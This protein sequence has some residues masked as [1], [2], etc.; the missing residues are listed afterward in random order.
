MLVRSRRLHSS[1]HGSLLYA[2]EGIVLD[3]AAGTKRGPDELS[4]ACI[5]TGSNSASAA[6]GNDRK[7][8]KGNS[9]KLK[10]KGD[11]KKMKGD[12]K[13]MKVDNKKLKLKG[14]REQLK[15]K[16]DSRKL[17]GDKFKIDSET[18]NLKLNCKKLKLKGD[19]SKL[20]IDEKLKFKLDCKEL[21]LRGDG[22]KLK[23]DGK[24][25]QGNSTKVKSFN[26]SSGVPSRV[27]CI[28]ELPGDVTEDEVIFLGLPFG[29]VTN[30]Q[31][32]KWENQAFIE[33]NTKE[34]AIT[35]VKHYTS[36]TP[37]L[38]GQPICIQ[39]SQHKELNT[40]RLHNQAQVQS[41][42]QALNSFQSRNLALAASAPA[43]GAGTIN[44]GPVGTMNSAA[45]DAVDVGAVNDVEVGAGPLCSVSSSS[46]SLGMGAV[47]S[48]TLDVGPVG[49]ATV[50]AGMEVTAQ[51]PVLR[52]LIEN[53]LNP[54]SLDMLHLIFSHFGKVL[55][56]I[57][58]TQNNTFQVLLQYAELLSAHLAKLFLDRWN[59]FGCT[60]HIS[61]STSS[62]LNVNYNN[63]NIRI[64]T[65]P[66]LPFCESQF[67]QD[68]SLALAFS[69][70]PIM[71]AP[72]Q[73]GAGFPSLFIP[74]AA[75]HCYPNELQALLSL[76]IASVSRAAI[77]GQI[78]L[79]GLAPVAIQSVLG[80]AA[81]G[82][83]AIPGPAP[84]AIPLMSGAA[85]AEAGQVAIPAPAQDENCVLLVSN[86]NPQKIRIRSLFIIFGVYGDV[87]RVK[88]FFK[89]KS[90]ALVQMANG[91]Q[92]KMAMSHLNGHVLYG[93]RMLITVT[94]HKV[95][96]LLRKG[97][98]D[99]GLTKDYSNSRLHR[100]R[101]VC[102]KYFQNVS[103]PSAHLYFNHIPR[104]TSSYHLK[105]LLSRKGRIVKKFRFFRKCR[106][107]A[108]AEMG[109]VGEAIHALIDLHNYDLGRGHHLWVNFSNR[110]QHHRKPPL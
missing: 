108:L 47:C 69:A 28:R 37:M 109:S 11:S 53:P 65:S 71:S 12:S 34:A 44:T 10:V 70:A 43:V 72:L 3:K 29:K 19:S 4:S 6:N 8:F 24:K 21:K 106:T 9:K 18:L 36:M 31:M 5:T 79:A 62:I 96:H 64:Y 1:P 50:D 103:P 27:I 110:P 81:A 93:K 82:Q 33:M 104:F 61:F 57:T 23:G 48:G 32:M 55:K 59:I 73:L 67:S 25:M 39:F 20:K 26:S 94:P 40:S 74:Q 107:M 45:V 102:S 17:N 42:L 14:D 13:K 51:K 99:L 90:Q 38:R 88:I 105:A 7:K 77:A 87:Q 60:V 95:V 92:A 22:S 97:Q 54:F 101:N 16:G 56:I 100:F 41:V 78:A 80:A 46:G 52:I 2:M 30:L 75:G 89:D 49:T 84:V 66:D 91:I 63:S 85:P 83:I 68:Q 15:L 58:F 98:A 86:L 35:M 76:A